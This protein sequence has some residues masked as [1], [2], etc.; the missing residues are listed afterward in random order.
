MPAFKNTDAALTASAPFLE[1]LEPTLLLSLLAGG[2]LGVM[3]R[4]RYPL[5]APLLGVGFVRG[6]E[7]AGIRCHLLRSSSE[8]FDV[9]LQTSFQQGGVRR[10][11][12]AHLVMR[13]DLVLRLLHQDQFAE[14]IG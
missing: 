3:A 8:Q 2:A 5:H 1:L 6:G 13:N 11:L 9:L 7:E 4:N 14:F 12:F 10:P